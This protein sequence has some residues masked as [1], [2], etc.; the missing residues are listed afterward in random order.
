MS[1]YY[2]FISGLP[3]LEFDTQ[4]GQ[5][6]PELYPGTLEDLLANAEVEWVRLLWIRQYHRGIVDYLSGEKRETGLPPGIPGGAFHSAAEEFGLLPEYLRKFVLWKEN[7]RAEL[8][9]PRI[10]HRLQILYFRQL[11]HAGNRFLR[12]WGVWEMN[13]LNFFAARRSELLQAEKKEQLIPGSSYSDLL[14]EFSCNQKIIHTEFSAVPQLEPL[15]AQ[16]DLLRRE[17][18]TDR[19]RWQ[20]IEEINRFEYFSVDV[21]LGYY[22]KLL[23]LER[24]QRITHARETADPLEIAGKYLAHSG[25]EE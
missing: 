7:D 2:S 25:I 15:L 12:H 5:K 22:Q 10:T 3:D 14:L 24:W 20:A 13:L 9:R 16:P 23:L 17:Q 18:E 4:G 6:L 8:P 21:I 19:L 11:L 1:A